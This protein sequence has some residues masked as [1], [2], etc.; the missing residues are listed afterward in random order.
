[1]RIDQ[2]SDYDLVGALIDEAPSAPKKR[3]VGLRV[4]PA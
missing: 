4:L 3:R 2:A 1:V